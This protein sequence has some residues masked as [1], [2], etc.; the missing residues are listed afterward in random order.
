M[1]GVAR[2]G[3]AWRGRRGKVGP[4]RLGADDYGGLGRGMAG[5]ARSGCDGVGREMVAEVRQARKVKA[6]G[7]ASWMR[8]VVIGWAWNGQAGRDWLGSL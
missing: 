8:L 2:A 4:A 5:G 6:R 1:M 7:V 3:M